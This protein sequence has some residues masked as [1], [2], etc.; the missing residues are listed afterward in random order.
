MPRTAAARHSLG[1]SSVRAGPGPGRTRGRRPSRGCDAAAT[2]DV[3]VTV[4][5][6]R[7][8]Q[9][10]AIR[11]RVSVQVGSAGKFQKV[12]SVRRRAR[13]VTAP[14]GRVCRG[15]PGPGR[16][17]DWG[18]VRVTVTDDSD[19]DPG[20]EP[21]VTAR[22]R[23]RPG[24]R[25]SDSESAKSPSPRRQRRR[26]WRRT[27]TAQVTAPAPGRPQ[28]QQPDTA[29]RPAGRPEAAATPSQAAWR[30]SESVTT[31]SAAGGARGGSWPP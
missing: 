6:D 25:T 5:R 20:P 26:R 29:R 8:V 23:S 28:A 31:R 13:E 15:L 7:A 9:H 21:A 14:G 30:H 4:T 1:L 22:A 27:V 2:R 17:P 16:E 19:A 3:T 12:D 18:M 24:S 11:I 10:E